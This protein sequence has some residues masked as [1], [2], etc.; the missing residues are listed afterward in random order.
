M[1]IC[2]KLTLGF[3][4]VI[5]LMATVGYVAVNTG[6]KQLQETVGRFSALLTA[7]TL[8]RVDKNF[9]ERIA[10]CQEY[11]GDSAL[12]QAVFESNRKFEK[13]DN[14]RIYINRVDKDWVDG[15]NTAAI[16]SVLNNEISEKLKKHLQFY[17]EKYG[18]AV[19]PEIYLTNRHGVVIASTGRTSDYLQ[20]D[21]Q[22]YQKAVAVKKFWVGEIEYD[23]SS[24][25]FASD[26]AVKIYDDYGNFAGIFKAILD[27]EELKGI[28]REA[29]T[30]AKYKTAEV[31]LATK[32]GKNICST[33]NCGFMEDVSGESWFRFCKE[34]KEHVLF[35]VEK[36][37]L[38]SHAH[39]GGYKDFKGLGWVLG[40]SYETEEIFAP[41]A[42]FKSGVLAVLA[43]T[44]AFA[45]MAGFLFA[46]SVSGQ[47]EK[48]KKAMREIKRGN[49][50]AELAVKAGNELGE[51]AQSF[52]DMAQ[53]L[54]KTSDELNAEITERRHTEEKLAELKS[55]LQHLLTSSPA[56]VYACDTSG[57]YAAT[58]I[59]EN[60]LEHLG[61]T[62][63]EFT[64]DKKFWVDRIHPG[65]K[66]RVF[67]E[68]ERALKKGRH[69]YQYR[70]LRKDGK[71]IWI[72][73]CFRVIYDDNG[74]PAEIVGSIMDINSHKGIEEKQTK[75]LEKVKDI[76][77]EL[78]DFAYIISH[79]L[80]APLRGVSTI[81]NW[82][83]ADYA[84]KLDENGK[85]QLTLLLS[86]VERMHNLIDGVL[87][88][89][90]AG[91]KQEEKVQVNLNDLVPE[92]IDAL[93]PPQ[94]IQVTVEG[95]L[96]TI[97]CGKTRITQVFQNLISNAV[98]YMDKPQGIIKVA[99]SEENGFWKFSVT[100]NGPGIE[101]KDHERIFKMFQ[102]LKPKDEFESTGVGLT[103][104]KKIVEMYEGKIWVESEPGQGSSFCFTLP[105]QENNVL[106]GLG[107]KAGIIGQ[108]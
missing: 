21:E 8:D 42:K 15:K 22:W 7:Q 91:T 63:N 23:E 35:T 25:S 39:S 97:S 60:V 12:R 13:L 37:K 59:S 14:I 38:F 52:N 53:N 54:K 79:D 78:K 65:D 86:R 5:S 51:L 87:Q 31:K 43:V 88:Y 19:F 80:K 20:A 45:V 104:A 36:G 99:C 66:E 73:D 108:Q 57:D 1:R 26:I 48:F 40:V 9:Y 17:R 75:L 32:N 102:T 67:A 33:D 62:S 101:E 72:M 106:N 94:N 50:N 56:I 46:K 68:I 84:D 85:E 64:S 77:E 58:Y 98:K 34:H 24:E 49:L 3:I 105:K 89:S 44:A 61:Y 41:I 6:Q 47:I 93:T 29:K 103:V 55:R 18:C 100:D 30:A 96:P 10:D 74:S 107:L 4:S 81:A 69:S 2:L 95:Q 82:L 11:S 76:N 70:F 92:I 28:A 27:I 16:Q 71:Y 90:R 83:A